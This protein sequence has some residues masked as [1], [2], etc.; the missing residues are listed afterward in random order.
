M[1]KTI[2]ILAALIVASNA[3]MAG[4]V[5][6]M[7]PWG[8]YDRDATDLTAD[9]GGVLENH[10]VLWQLLY[11]G[12]NNKVDLIDWDNSGNGYVSG[13]DEVIGTRLLSH[14]NSGVFDDMLYCEEDM[15]TA[16]DLDYV[17]S[18]SDPYYVFQRVYDSQ[19]PVQG[20]TAYYESGLTLLNKAEYGEDG[21]Q[22]IPLPQ[23]G[24]GGPDRNPVVNWNEGVRVSVPEPATMSL[25]GLGALAMVL[26]RKL[27]K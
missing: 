20:Q 9:E 17:Y 1:K 13:D 11:A 7:V 27:R 25:L 16:Y 14:G 22:S 18:D 4:T 8:V 2:G 5:L 15:D 6:W 3:A 19:T 21:L 26:R 24:T 10:D 23:T 12:A